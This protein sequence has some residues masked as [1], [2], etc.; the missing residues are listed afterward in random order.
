MGMNFQHR[1][2]VWK[3]EGDTC[4]FV[5]TQ[6]DDLFGDEYQVEKIPAHTPDMLF[7]N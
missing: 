2:P 5:N 1:W 3:E 4:I 6:P 7:K